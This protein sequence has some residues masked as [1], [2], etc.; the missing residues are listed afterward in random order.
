MNGMQ[1]VFTKALNNTLA[2]E[3]NA[4]VDAME[5]LNNSWN[6]LNIDLN[7]VIAHLKSL[8]ARWE[9]NNEAKENLEKWLSSLESKILEKHDFKADVGEMKTLFERLNH[10][11]NE[12]DEKETDFNHVIFETEEL[13]KFCKNNHLNTDIKQ[14]KTRK[15]ILKEKTLKRKDSLENEILQH[16][17]Y[18]QALQESE[19]WLLQ[20]SFQLMAHNSLYITNRIQT[21]EQIK[22]HQV[23]LNEIIQ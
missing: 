3:R 23:L 5:E 2:A 9:E 21:Q 17:N 14:L 16:S 6:S 18:L 8:Q 4:L 1:E 11:I 19:K 15:N 7:S 22:H 13:S 12:I 10:M 20:I